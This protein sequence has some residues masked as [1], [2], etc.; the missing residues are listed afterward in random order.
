M[1]RITVNHDGLEGT[2][3][4][5]DKASEHAKD[6]RHMDG[7]SGQSESMPMSIDAGVLFGSRPPP[8]PTLN[9]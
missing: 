5:L 7:I 9:R 2:V 1:R 8:R 3:Y 6:A 4:Q